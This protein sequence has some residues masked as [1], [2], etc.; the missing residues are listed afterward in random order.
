L[1]A[2]T[3]EEKVRKIREYIL[4][5]GFPSE[6]EIG[7]ILR[8]NGWIVVNQSPY[9]DEISKK[10]RTIDV[11][12]IKIGL[13]PPTIGFQLVIECKKSHEH[14]WSFHTQQKEGEFFPALITI[15]ELLK[16]LAHPPLLAKLQVLAQSYTLESL[17]GLRPS[18]L[19]LVNKLSGL[20]VLDKN[21]R[22][23][24][25]P[26]IPS[27]KNDFFDAVQQIVS[28]LKGT[29]NASK[30]LIM[31]PAIV[32]DGE[33]YEFYQENNEMKVL[34]VNHIQFIAFE[35]NMTPFIIDVVRKTHFSEFL[36]LIEQDFTIYRELL[37]VK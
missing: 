15:I 2:H 1:S 24:I 22:V 5:S 26:V 13:Q 6:I 31:F 36:K 32:F 35:D 30:S 11:L 18:S 10:V 9:M 21:I 7:N 3:E 34:P 25:F 12:A 19:E 27:K 29:R 16:R 4:K 8:R 23:G 28:A 17:F 14:E 37:N 20:H 33:M